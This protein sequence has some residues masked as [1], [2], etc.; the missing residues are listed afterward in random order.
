L[1]FQFLQVIDDLVHLLGLEPELRHR[2]VTSSNSFPER[3]LK[4]FDRVSLVQIAERRRFR[5]GCRLVA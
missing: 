5:Q 4:V 2:D 1:A 3:L